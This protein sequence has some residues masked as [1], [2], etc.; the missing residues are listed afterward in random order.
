MS[1]ATQ[2][3]ASTVVGSGWMHDIVSRL[4][5]QCSLMYRTGIH[6][7]Y[8]CIPAAWLMA[9]RVASMAFL[10]QVHYWSG[11]LVRVHLQCTVPHGTGAR[12]LKRISSDSMSRTGE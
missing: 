7:A 10:A 3:A 11:Q 12:I 2:S 4:G 6:F 5:K 9:V 1:R 8:C